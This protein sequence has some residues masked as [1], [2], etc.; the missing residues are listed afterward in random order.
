MVFILPS[1]LYFTS[2]DWFTAPSV[3]TIAFSL[4]SRYNTRTVQTITSSS[5]K[6]SSSM[7][8]PEIRSFL[9]LPPFSPLHLTVRLRRRNSSHRAEAVK[10]QPCTFSLR[11]VKDRIARL[12]SA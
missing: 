2:D 3:I 9:A 11:T 4:H 8:T 7:E 12:L 10:G 5:E 1:I 6:L